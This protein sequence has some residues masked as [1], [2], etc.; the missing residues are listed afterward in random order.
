MER[1]YLTSW[2]CTICLETCGSGAAT[3]REATPV[4]HRRIR[5]TIVVPTGCFVAVAGTALRR[6]CG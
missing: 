6:A 1:S 2:G 4:L 5:I 3:G